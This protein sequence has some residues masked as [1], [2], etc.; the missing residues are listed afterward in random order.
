MEFR[1]AGLALRQSSFDITVARLHLEPSTL[2]ALFE[3]E[4]AGC[5]FL[6][7]R[8]PRILYE[9]H[10]F[11]RLTQGVYDDGDI[12]ARQPGGYG[13]L[14]TA[15]YDRLLRAMQLDLSLIHISRA[16]ETPEHLV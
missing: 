4:T 1:G 7:D 8:R 5:G 15:Q 6:R 2:W 13:A 10:V 11:H 12:S 14:G 9:R 16:H 3:V